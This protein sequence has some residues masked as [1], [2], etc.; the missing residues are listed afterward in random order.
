MSLLDWC[1]SGGDP[2][3]IG[4]VRYDNNDGN[5][6]NIVRLSPD[7]CH[8]Q[9]MSLVYQFDGKIPRGLR[10]QSCELFLVQRDLGFKLFD[11]LKV[12]FIG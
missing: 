2:T 3:N 7:A 9:L 11:P 5:K 4:A 8:P 10:Q 1:D 6:F 12:S